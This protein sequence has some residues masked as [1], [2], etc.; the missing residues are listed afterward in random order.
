M[1]SVSLLL[2]ATLH[3]ASIRIFFF[4]HMFLLTLPKLC[5]DIHYTLKCV[6]WCI[7]FFNIDVLLSLERSGSVK[8]KTLHSFIRSKWTCVS[9]CVCGRSAW[10][11]LPPIPLPCFVNYIVLHMS[12]MKQGSFCCSRLPISITGQKGVGW[13]LLSN[14]MQTCFLG[15]S[16]VCDPSTEPWP[17]LVLSYACWKVHSATSSIQVK[18][19]SLHTWWWT[20]WTNIHD[21]N[22]FSQVQHFLAITFLCQDLQG[23][24][25]TDRFVDKTH[26][27]TNQ[28]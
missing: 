21:H 17:P 3:L 25:F 22:L 12:R 13:C 10:P 20:G 28:Y 2:E 11:Q 8:T 19:C 14:R 7:A 1:I 9:V 15:K 4:I 6:S 27:H 16:F 23:Q 5:S 24:A 18:E 26:C